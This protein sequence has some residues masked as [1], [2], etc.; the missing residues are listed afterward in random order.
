MWNYVV[1]YCNGRYVS[2]PIRLSTPIASTSSRVNPGKLWTL[3]DYDVCPRW[4]NICSKGTTLVG[5]LITRDAVQVWGQS[6]WKKCLYLLLSFTNELLYKTTLNN[7]IY[8]KQN[9]SVYLTS[10]SYQSPCWQVRNVRQEVWAATSWDPRMF[11]V[12]ANGT[13]IVTYHPC[14]TLSAQVTSTSFSLPAVVL[15]HLERGFSNPT[16][17]STH[18]A[19]WSRD[20]PSLLSPAQ[21]R[22]VHRINDCC[23]KLLSFGVFIRYYVMGWIGSYQIHVLKTYPWYLGMG[24]YLDIRFFWKMI[25]FKWGH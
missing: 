21:I 6:T 5:V 12:D 15:D 22:F 23:F 3:G 2:L 8:S 10:V 17:V 24:L 13:E 19:A 25:L 4:L 7:K 20:E 9:S 1:W 16:W 11:S 18:D 14:P